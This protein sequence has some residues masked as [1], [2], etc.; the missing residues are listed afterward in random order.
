MAI[1][2]LG[3]YFF[4]RFARVDDPAAPPAIVQ[5]EVEV[6]ERKG[7]DGAGILRTGRRG[8]AFQMR[9]GLDWPNRALADQ[10][11]DGYAAMIGQQRFNLVW[12]STDYLAV[13]NCQYLVLDVQSQKIQRLSASV[14]GLSPGGLFW[15][16]ALWTLLPVPGS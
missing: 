11:Q 8:K 1:Y 6:V 10:A 4:V 5:G 14:G 16:E 3:N 7:V 2:S 9:S 13:H 15:H 12:G